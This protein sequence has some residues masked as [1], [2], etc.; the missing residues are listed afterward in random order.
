MSSHY[1]ELSP[2]KTPATFRCHGFDVINHDLPHLLTRSCSAIIVHGCSPRHMVLGAGAWWWCL[3]TMLDV[4]S[5]IC[6]RHLTYKVD[7]VW[8]GLVAHAYARCKVVATSGAR[9]RCS[10]R[11]RKLGGV[12][13]WH[14]NKRTSL[15]MY[16]NAR[17][18]VNIRPHTSAY[19][20]TH[21][22]IHKNIY[23]YTDIHSQAYTYATKTH[24]K[25]KTKT[26]KHMFINT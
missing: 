8:C 20:D 9:F 19:T 15:Y 11:D 26:H 25:T 16:T 22:Y 24:M 7:N 17:V 3:I 1:L 2:N 5:L 18:V 21:T 6:L 10:S 23:M 4:R 14:S 13:A 12:A